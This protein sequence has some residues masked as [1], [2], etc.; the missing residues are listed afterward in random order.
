MEADKTKACR[1]GRQAGDP[2]GAAGAVQSH[3]PQDSHKMSPVDRG[4]DRTALSSEAQSAHPAGNHTKLVP[5]HS[6]VHTHWQPAEDYE[7][8]GR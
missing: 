8:G 3:L 4:T 6:V 2:R 1:T 5:T 7:A